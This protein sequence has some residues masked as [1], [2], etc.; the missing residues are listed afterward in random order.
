MRRFYF[1]SLWIIAPFC[2]LL[3]A[4]GGSASPT[5]PK[6]RNIE[7]SHQ[8]PSGSLE[9]I[10]LGVSSEQ[11]SENGFFPYECDANL[12]KTKLEIA[13]FVDLNTKAVA[14][15]LSAGSMD[16]FEQLPAAT[17]PS[18]SGQSRSIGPI[19]IN[20]REEIDPN[21][22]DWVI[23][24]DP[25]WEQLQQLVADARK[26]I[27]E[28]NYTGSIPYLQYLD[29][30]LRARA[31]DEQRRRIHGSNYSLHHDNMRD[32]AELH[33]QMLACEADAN[34]VPAN[35]E[36]R[37]SAPAAAIMKDT[38][39]YS[40]LYEWMMLEASSE[41]GRDRMRIFSKWIDNDLRFYRPHNTEA[42]R[43]LSAG[44]FE[45]MLSSG[46][47]GHVEKEITDF[48]AELW[49]GADRTLKLSFVSEGQTFAE[50]SPFRFEVL[51]AQGR[52]YV[53]YGERKVALPQS[54][55]YGTLHHEMGHV[56]GL[57]DAYYTTYNTKTCLYEQRSR[58]RDLMSDSSSGSVLDDHWNLLE[59]LYSSPKQ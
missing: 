45:V 30:Q 29:Y 38:Y 21:S 22:P 18:P 19:S 54:I 42:V 12:E 47:L 5:A 4:C 13:Q 59:T 39:V 46:P 3:S 32:F 41:E 14:Q 51:S 23:S 24:S 53:S 50:L 25:T 48:V 36:S 55:Q 33:G 57:K 10:Y 9:Q 52:G 44:N 7:T 20:A 49:S 34:C 1:Q 37:L 11:A 56:L 35:F 58:P 17:A 16:S 28:H 15:A 31:P 27:T 43:R 8:L 2:T 40:K 6:H 26:L